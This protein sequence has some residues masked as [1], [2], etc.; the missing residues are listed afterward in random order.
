MSKFIKVL[1]LVALAASVTFNIV[2]VHQLRRAI[3]IG[4]DLSSA[5]KRLIE[6]DA[7]LK[8]ACGNLRKI[9][10]NQIDV[11]WRPE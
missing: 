8:K 10:C 6:A 3:E 9:M 7:R 1:L 11:S 5:N 4:I 2:N